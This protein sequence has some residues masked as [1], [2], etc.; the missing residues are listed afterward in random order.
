MDLLAVVRPPSLSEAS[1]WYR[2]RQAP[3]LSELARKLQDPSSPAKVVARAEG[4]EAPGT[5]LLALA[6][7]DGRNVFVS[8][9]DGEVRLSA[10]REETAAVED[11]EHGDWDEDGDEEVDEPIEEVALGVIE[12]L[13]VATGWYVFGWNSDEFDPGG[14]CPTCAIEYFFWQESCPSCGVALEVGDAAPEPLDAPGA[15]EADAHALVELLLDGERIELVSIA[16]RAAVEATVATAL[17]SVGA[18]LEQLLDSLTE[19]PG[20]AEVYCDED[21]LAE[22]LRQVRTQRGAARAAAAKSRSR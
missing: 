3:S 21:E 11:E 22:A 19:L 15:E 17:A 16:S 13:Q 14:A 6:A 10:K 8:L 9:S 12:T 5:L 20:V 4:T 18:S 2:A 1:P 7:S